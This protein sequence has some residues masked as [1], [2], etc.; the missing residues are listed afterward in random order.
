MISGSLFFNKVS[1][2][3]TDFLGYTREELLGTPLKSLIIK[4]DF[5]KQN[6]IDRYYFENKICCK[7]G[8]TKKIKWRLIPDVLEDNIVYVGWEV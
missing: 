2:S 1:T 6:K 7:D 4:G 5:P 3:F 8:T